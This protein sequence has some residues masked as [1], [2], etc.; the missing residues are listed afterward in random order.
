MAWRHRANAGRAEL[1][2]NVKIDKPMLTGTIL[3]NYAERLTALN[4]EIETTTAKL[5]AG[6]V[7][8]VELDDGRKVS[9]VYA[10][11]TGELTVMGGESLPLAFYAALEDWR[12]VLA[13]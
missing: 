6:C 7:M 12:K 13:Q 2:G 4:A 5:D 1:G 11:S 9:A 10:P 3:R 8:R